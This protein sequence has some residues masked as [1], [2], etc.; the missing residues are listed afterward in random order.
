MAVGLEGDVLQRVAAIVF[1]QRT[2]INRAARVTQRVDHLMLEDAHQPGF[3]LRAIAN[4][5]LPISN[6]LGFA[7]VAKAVSE[8]ATSARA[9]LRN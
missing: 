3:K 2:G 1:A 6:G 5:Q 7:N 4:C 9:S 8:T